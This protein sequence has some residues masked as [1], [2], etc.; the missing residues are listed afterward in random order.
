MQGGHK[1]GFVEVSLGNFPILNEIL[2]IFV[3]R[4]NS[5]YFQIFISIKKRSYD[6]E[7][8]RFY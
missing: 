2:Y 1:I 5:L 8:Y 7:P 3:L 4:W 6:T